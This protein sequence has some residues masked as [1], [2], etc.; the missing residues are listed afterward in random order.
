[1][2]ININASLFTGYNNPKVKGNYKLKDWL[3]CGNTNNEDIEFIETVELIRTFTLSDYS[4]LKTEYKPIYKVKDIVKTTYKPNLPAITPSLQ[5]KVNGK[6]GNKSDIIQ[7][8]GFIQYDIDFKENKHITNYFEL[9]EQLKK[10]PE[11]VS[12]MLSVSGNG[13]WGLVA[14]SDTSKHLQHFQALENAFKSINIVID[15]ACKDIGRL[16]GY[17]YDKEPYINENAKVFTALY[18][19]R[20]P[21][22]IIPKINN[23]SNGNNTYSNKTRVESCLNKIQAQNIDITADYHTW[24]QLAYSIASEF[25]ISGKQYFH[26]TSQYYSGYNYK[27]SDTL[28]SNAC[29]NNA[30]KVDISLFFKVC[31]ENNITFL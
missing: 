13:F 19:P 1:M 31:K 26:I 5:Y 11:I 30:I 20:K 12:C 27:E 23:Y 16:R 29:K 21:K 25:G 24:V 8:T 2:D 7:H 4:D 18:E 15:T 10:I 9:K 3:L 28:Y 17:S 22:K 14:I 6:R